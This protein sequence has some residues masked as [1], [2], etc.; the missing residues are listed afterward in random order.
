MRQRLGILH[1]FQNSGSPLSLICISYLADSAWSCPS[2]NPWPP[3]IQPLREA[4]E[5]R[6]P[7][8]ACELYP[9][10]GGSGTEVLRGQ[11]VVIT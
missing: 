7:Q 9:W 8:N 11:E 5:G 4:V 1:N 3:G 10:Q 6:G 2:I